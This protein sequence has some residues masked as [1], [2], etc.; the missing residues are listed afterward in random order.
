MAAPLGYVGLGTIGLPVATRLAATGAPL[1][2]ADLD[3]AALATLRGLENVTV[4]PTPAA[5]AEAC[6]VLFACLPNPAAGEAVFLGED[7]VASAARPG[8]VVVDNSTVDPETAGRLAAGL[9]ERGARYFECPVLGGVA[10]AE[11][12]ELFAIVSGPEAEYTTHVRQYLGTFSRDHRYV[13]AAVGAASRM[14]TV[15]NGLGLVQW[16]GIVEALGLM[17]KAGADLGMWYDVVT[18]GGGMAGTPLFEARKIV[19]LS[20]FACCPSR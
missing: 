18:L 14:K 12:G 4:L 3:P 16:A 13:G 8:L 20:R 1:F 19:I 9:G 2:V 17:A 5:V 6:S 11:S 10:Q 15:Q 7:G